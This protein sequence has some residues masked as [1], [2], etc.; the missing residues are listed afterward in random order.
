MTVAETLTSGM[1]GKQVK[2]EFTSDWDNLK[3]TAV[4]EASDISEAVYNVGNTVAIPAAVLAIAR[5]RLK[6]GIYGEDTEGNITPTIYAIG[7]RIE[8]GAD[9]YRASGDPP[10]PKWKE[11]EERIED[12]EK[13]TTGGGSGSDSGQNGNGLSTELKTALINYYTHVMPNFDDANGLS[14]IN[15]ILTALGAETREEPSEPEE[16]DTPVEPDEP[17]TPEVTLTSISAVYS[18]GDVAVGTAVTDL[19][20]I[21]VTAHYSNGTSETVTGYTLS[22]TIAEGSNT[23]TVSY[24]GKTATFTVTGVAES[25]GDDSGD[26]TV[27]IPADATRLAYIESTGTQYIDTEYQPAAKDTI[28]LT[29]ETAYAGTS[30]RVDWFGASDGTN[31]FMAGTNLQYVY[32]GRTGNNSRNSA[33]LAS[34]W[35]GETGD[36][37]KLELQSSIS[38]HANPGFDCSSLG[39]V[40]NGVRVT[41]TTNLQEVQCV[42]NDIQANMYLFASNNNGALQRQSSMKL[43]ECI[44]YDVNGA[45][46]HHYVPV[47][48]A[49]NVVCLYD[50]IDKRYL[51]NAGTGDFVG[52]EAA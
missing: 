17:D 5:R 13:G 42:Y 7:P 6:I 8:E 38:Y 41:G 11:L 35:F 39:C 18:G 32:F 34:V 33:P 26:T 4:F 43:Y 9:P 1:V 52:G 47:K 46:V 45:E 10:M 48:D 14:Y 2:L 36:H 37:V 23:V 27:E 20:G 15:A 31:L 12:L 21:V 40:A 50:T 44:F 29:M 30:A 49:N 25:G 3:K 16:P 24:G 22:G 19:T 28:E 51:Y